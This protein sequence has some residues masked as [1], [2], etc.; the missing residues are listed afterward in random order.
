MS[1][2]KKGTTKKAATKKTTAKKT[3]TRSMDALE[4]LKKG[5]P[6]FHVSDFDPKS[7]PSASN[8]PQTT[9][10]LGDNEE[11]TGN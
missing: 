7:T 1:P 9:N 11:Q 10:S 6:V 5:N 3:P 4:E 8:D 2:A